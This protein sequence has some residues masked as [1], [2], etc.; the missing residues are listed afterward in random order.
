[1]ESGEI[2]WGEEMYPMDGRRHKPPIGH[3][4]A[5]RRLAAVSSRAGIR[6]RPRR[7]RP[8]AAVG[9]RGIHGTALTSPSIA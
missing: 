7:F 2:A 6:T 5:Y 1:M 8:S 9:A 3:S 4:A